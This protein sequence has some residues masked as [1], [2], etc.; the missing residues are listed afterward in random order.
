MHIHVQGDEKV[1]MSIN[2]G[3]SVMA[4]SMAIVPPLVDEVAVAFLESLKKSKYVPYTKEEEEE[5]MR[6]MDAIFAARKKLK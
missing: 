1:C 2:K 3:V 5:T 6:K 4:V